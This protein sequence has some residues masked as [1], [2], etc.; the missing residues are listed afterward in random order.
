VIALG[1]FD[2]VHRG[3]RAMLDLARTAAEP[4][5]R[6]VVAVTF[7]PHPRAVVAGG[8]PPLL[9][10]IEERVERILAAGAD[11][12]EVVPF[13]PAFSQLTPGAFVDDWLVGRLGSA[14][15]VVGHNFRFGHRAAG[16]LTTLRELC[17]AHDVDVVDCD[18]L[19]DGDQPVSSSRIR[20]LL[21]GG[22]TELANQ[23]LGFAYDVTGP[24]EHGARRGRELGMPT[25]N[26]GIPAT[27]LVPADG[28]YGGIAT[29]QGERFAAATSVGTNPQFTADQPHPPRTVEVH[30]IG[31]DG[32]DF[33]GE[34]LHV[35]FEQF[36]RGQRTFDSIDL[37]VEQMQQDLRDVEA[38][39]AERRSLH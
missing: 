33:Y 25:A 32:P 35:T 23:L 2:G 3:H 11:R 9:C 15:V 7:D 16:D 39:I 18:L 21:A 38:G 29:L 36:I 10:S 24:V 20:T 37:L 14:A 30:L 4:D 12:V 27:R 6:P 5:S 8:A 19:V 13:T 1:T 28:V 31:Y 22:N 26:L 34:H 17:R